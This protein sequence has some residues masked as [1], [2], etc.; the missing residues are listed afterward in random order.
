VPADTDRFHSFALRLIDDNYK[1]SVLILVIAGFALGLVA[2]VAVRVVRKFLAAPSVDPRVD[3]DAQPTSWSSIAARAAAALVAVGATAAYLL[4]ELGEHFVEENA[5]QLPKLRAIILA[6]AFVSALIPA[7]RPR[8]SSLA[9]GVLLGLLTAAAIGVVSLFAMGAVNSLPAAL[10]VLTVTAAPVAGGAAV[11]ALAVSFAAGL[12]ADLDAF[13]RL[14]RFALGCALVGG[15]SYAGYVW[16]HQPPALDPS[17]RLQPSTWHGEM[18]YGYRAYPFKLVIE[19]VDGTGQFVGYM[20]W[21]PEH[22]LKIEGKATA[23]H[24]VFEDTEF[25]RGREQTGI[26]DRKDVWITGN[27]MRGTDK[28]GRAQLEAALVVEPLVVAPVVGVSNTVAIAVPAQAAPRMD[29]ALLVRTEMLC[30]ELIA[31]H[32]DAFAAACWSESR[33]GH[34]PQRSPAHPRQPP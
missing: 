11:I 18:M 14:A 23:N 27:A 30:G 16:Y 3:A 12:I 7:L 29:A 5:Q 9:L 15:C 33:P 20:D 31:M 2:I 1:F 19:R 10:I 32:E 24:L 8:W 26:F 28:N 21:D 22:R 25:L 13:Q 34:H 17:F 6:I 4:S